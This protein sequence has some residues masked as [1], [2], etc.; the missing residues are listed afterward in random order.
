MHA[1]EWSEVL[2]N[3]HA[4]TRRLNLAL[5]AN[6]TLHSLGFKQSVLGRPWHGGSRD[7]GG[8]N[9]R[10]GPRGWDRPLSI[11]TLL[12]VFRLL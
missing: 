9:Q 8:A 3:L 1:N 11:L 6:V 4:L 7:A 10:F 2:P 5:S 12:P